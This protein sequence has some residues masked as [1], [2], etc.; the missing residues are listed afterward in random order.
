[1]VNVCEGDTMFHELK[2]WVENVHICSAEIVLRIPSFNILVS[3]EEQR[4]NTMP[5]VRGQAMWP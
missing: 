1:M 2:F 5:D 3:H 4:G